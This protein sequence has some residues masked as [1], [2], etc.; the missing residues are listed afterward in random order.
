[1][2]KRL[3]TL[4]WAIR[5]QGKFLSRKSVFSGLC[6]RKISL[7][8]L[9]TTDGR[10]DRRKREQGCLQEASYGLEGWLSSLE[11][12]CCYRRPRFYSQFPHGDS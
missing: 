12:C 10:S 9:G 7:T 5:H 2:H 6:F 8:G 1:M 3:S 11:T 4:P